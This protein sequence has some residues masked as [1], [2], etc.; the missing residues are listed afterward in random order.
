[1]KFEEKDYLDWKVQFHPSV[2]LQERLD[3]LGISDMEFVKQCNTPAETIKAFLK[4]ES[5]ITVEMAQTFE[6]VLGI[7]ARFWL[8]YQRLYN[9]THGIP[10]LK[11]Q[12]DFCYKTNTICQHRCNGLCKESC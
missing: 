3:E 1:M 2:T 10:Q 5:S 8:N 7:P 12:P 6:K 9:E 4:S 11:D